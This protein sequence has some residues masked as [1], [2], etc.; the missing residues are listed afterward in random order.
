MKQKTPEKKERKKVGRPP[1]VFDSKELERVKDLACYGLSNEQIC[2][3]MGCGL[4]KAT[5]PG[6]FSSAIKVGRD[7]GAEGLFHSAYH[8]AVVEKNPAMIMFLLKCK[9][10]FR[11][12]NE[13][14]VTHRMEPIIIT[15][16][17]D[18]SVIELSHAQKQL[19]AKEN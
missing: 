5:D 11:E 15:R 14:D 19:E 12:K 3:I 9:H 13:L 17:S 7:L 8:L 18:G 4:S 1:I 6:E 10:G 16:P 2:R